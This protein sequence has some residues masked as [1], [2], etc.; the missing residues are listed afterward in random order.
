M[1]VSREPVDEVVLAAVLL[2]GDDDDVAPF[3]E[4]GCRSCHR[5]P[6]LSGKSF[7]IVRARR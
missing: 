4:T 6:F 1:H 7:W 3:R 5:S 2:V